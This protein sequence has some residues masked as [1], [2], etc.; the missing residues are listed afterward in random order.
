[1]TSRPSTT[2][3]L[4]SLALVE[5]YW[6]QDHDG[7]AAI[8]AAADPADLARCLAWSLA[9]PPPARPRPRPGQAPPGRQPNP[10]PRTGGQPMT[11]DRREGMFRERAR[12]AKQQAKREK[13]AQRRA[14][15]RV[16]RHQYDDDQDDDHVSDDR[17]GAWLSHGRCRGGRCPAGSNALCGA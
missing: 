1:M 4:D 10:A 3:L 17:R 14:G 15:R 11:S 5:C 2:A 7:I 12:Q 9:S 6:R 13:R 16:G 8:L